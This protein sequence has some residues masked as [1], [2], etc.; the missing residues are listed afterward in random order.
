MSV[1]T[2]QLTGPENVPL[3]RLTKSVSRT[4]PSNATY[5][6]PVNE[7]NTPGRDT[8]GFDRS[9]SAVGGFCC[10]AEA[11]VGGGVSRCPVCPSAASCASASRSCASQLFGRCCAESSRLGGL[12][13]LGPP[14]ASCSASWPFRWV[15]AT[16][17]AKRDKYARLCR[18]SF[19]G[20]GG[21]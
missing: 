3:R 7:F 10:C 20:S 4:V 18:S 15:K 12:L 16:L 2:R 9:D 13:L 8:S 11:D 21:G 17:G 1:V 6:F 19:T 5:R 14:P